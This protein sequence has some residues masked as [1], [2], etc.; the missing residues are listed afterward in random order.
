MRC[1]TLCTS[2]KML[3]FCGKISIN[4]MGWNRY[5]VAFFKD[6]HDFCWAKQLFGYVRLFMIRS[7]SLRACFAII[8][9]GKQVHG[10]AENKNWKI[11][12]R[13]PYVGIFVTRSIPWWTCFSI[14][15][16]L[17]F[18]WRPAM[19]TEPVTAG[20][21]CEA[22]FINVGMS[23]FLSKKKVVVC[24]LIN[25]EML[26][27]CFPLKKAELCNAYISAIVYNVIW[28]VGSIYTCQVLL[29]IN[30]CMTRLVCYTSECSWFVLIRRELVL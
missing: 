15:S 30:T 1:E 28:H 12:T 2:C 20:V 19:G 22:F 11:I 24:F 29:F 7:I 25:V 6:V 16:D 21:I 4:P 26:S 3:Q 18:G 5:K 13:L 10:C 27:F 9:D 14:T 17:F 8:Y 23:C